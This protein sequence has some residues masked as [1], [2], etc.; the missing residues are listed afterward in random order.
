MNANRTFIYFEI[1]ILVEA[2]FLSVDPYMRPYA[3]RL[4]QEGSTMIGEQVGK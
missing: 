3:A 1:E 4:L 2:L